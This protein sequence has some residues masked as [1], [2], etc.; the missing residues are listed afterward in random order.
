MKDFSNLLAEVNNR[1]KASVIR[2]LLKFTNKPGLISFAGGMP[3]PS[4]FPVKDITHFMS[5]AVEKNAHVAL[6]YGQTEGEPGFVAELIKLLKSDENI[7]VSGEQILVTSAS[8]Q[9]LDV[10]TKAF[11]NP[12]DIILVGM[13]TYLGALQTFQSY[14]ARMVGV[15]SDNDGMIPESV[16][17]ELETLKKAGK[18]CKFIYVVPDFQN[19][20]GTTIPVE[21][22][23]KILEL[24]K[25]HGALILE[26][27]PYRKIRFEGEHQTTFYALDK[28]EGNVMTMF[29]FS[30]TFVPGF[31]LGYIV[32]HK[33]LIRKFCILKQSMDLCSSPVC[34]AVTMEYLKAGKLDAHV[35]KI[36]EIYGKKRDAMLKALRTY[37]PAGVSWTEPKGGLFLWVMLPEYIN[38]TEMFPSALEQKVAYVIGSAFYHD[39]SVNNCMRLNFSYATFEQIDEGIKR[40]AAA[41]KKNIR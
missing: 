20:T 19:P 17:K 41:I 28:G 6:Q 21:R 8:Q 36:V 13:P 35:R 4:A 18:R 5:E 29:T 10:V 16:E 3:D 31:R 40:L 1:A 33:D 14:G 27:S 9:A 2:E 32:A 39:G 38:C 15:E 11:I 25:K 26:D 12:G 30:K 7:E 34:Q 24:A 22:R 37:M 23:V